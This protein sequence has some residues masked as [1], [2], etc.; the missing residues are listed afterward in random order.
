MAASAR[1]IRAIRQE[2]PMTAV[3]RVF[4]SFA[5]ATAGV[6]QAGQA[7]ICYSPAVD[8]GVV[9]PPSN[10]TVFQCPVSGGKTLPQL[11]AEGWSVVQMT[12]LQVSSTQQATQLVIQK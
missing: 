1:P 12:P 4:A 6:A 2:V 3:K 10:S 7:E 11:A 8:F 9:S 5:L